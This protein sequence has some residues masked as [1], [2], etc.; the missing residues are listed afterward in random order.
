MRPVAVAA[1]QP[2]VQVGPKRLCE[3]QALQG[4]IGI[5]VVA[6]VGQA[7]RRTPA[8]VGILAQLQEQIV[9]EQHLLWHWCILVGV[10]E[11]RLADACCCS[12]GCLLLQAFEV[13]ALK[14]MAA[15]PVLALADLAAAGRQIT[16]GVRD[17]QHNTMNI[18]MLAC[19]WARH[20]KA[21]NLGI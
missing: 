17:E 16:D 10:Q 8:A 12:F 5:A 21:C 7:H 18:K 20:G 11:G 19:V 15:A 2:L 4:R 1:V 14:L 6:V 9:R 3:Q 13:L